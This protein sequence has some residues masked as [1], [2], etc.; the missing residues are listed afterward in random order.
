MRYKRTYFKSKIDRIAIRVNVRE[1]VILMSMLS[2]LLLIG[3]FFDFTLVYGQTSIYD[4]FDEA[5][6]TKY[7]IKGKGTTYELVEYYQG[8]PSYPF[9][10]LTV[11]WVKIPISHSRVNISDI[12]KRQDIN[13]LYKDIANSQDLVLVT[14][15]YF[16]NKL[17]EGLVISKGKRLSSKV[18]WNDLGGVL[19]QRNSVI[20]IEPIKSFVEDSRITE[21]LQS[22]PILVK[23]GKIDNLKPDNLRYDKVAIGITLDNELIVVGSFNR[24]G[25]GISNYEFA[26]L[27]SIHTKSIGSD[28]PNIQ[29]ALY[30]DGGPSAHIYISKLGKHYGESGT[31]F[32]PN[33]IH[34]REED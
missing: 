6:L 4:F 10:G 11:C 20:S 31:T 16:K 34:V 15:G 21:A 13:A 18:R 29:V 1:K 32:V 12:Q 28:I 9:W 23:D 22:K 3:V 8:K 19:V 7:K 30:L 27:L 17:P 5:K 24:A 14:G 26:Q 25:D 2:V 33:I